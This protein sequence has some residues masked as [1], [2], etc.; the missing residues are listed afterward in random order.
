MVFFGFFT[1]VN[2]TNGG[3]ERNTQNFGK[4]G[5]ILK[6]EGN[7]YYC[8]CIEQYLRNYQ[9]NT[10]SLINFV[11]INFSKKDYSYY[12]GAEATVKNFDPF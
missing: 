4:C 9:N 10:F 12:S 5:E 2:R 3:G 1:P 7:T 11:E 8:I 6:I